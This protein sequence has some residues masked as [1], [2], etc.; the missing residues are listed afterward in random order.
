MIFAWTIQ[1]YKFENNVSPSYVTSSSSFASIYVSVMF[2]ELMI[3][4]RRN[5]LRVSTNVHT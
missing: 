1:E 2:S 5:I 3:N 4:E